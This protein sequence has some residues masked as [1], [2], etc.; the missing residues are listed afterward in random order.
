[1]KALL[2]IRCTLHH[3]ISRALANIGDLNRI[4]VYDSSQL[5]GPLLKKDVLRLLVPDHNF[6]LL[7]QFQYKQTHL[8]HSALD[9]LTGG[10]L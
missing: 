9:K 5:V 1:M 4:I 3:H 6:V 7:L 10:E 8:I 2:D